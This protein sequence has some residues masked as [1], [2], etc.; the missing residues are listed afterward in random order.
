[1]IAVSAGC[2]E[3]GAG[4]PNAVKLGGV[5]VH[6]TQQTPSMETLMIRYA[7]PLLLAFAAVPVLPAYSVSKAAFLAKLPSAMLASMRVKS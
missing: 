5:P 6:L 3:T 1:M 2:H 4:C 7:L